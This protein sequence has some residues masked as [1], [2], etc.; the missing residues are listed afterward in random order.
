MSRR[1]T[2]PKDVK[3][4]PNTIKN[5]FHGRPLLWTHLYVCDF[6][7]LFLFFCFLFFCFSDRWSQD[8]AAGTPFYTCS[9]WRLLERP[10]ETALAQVGTETSWKPLLP[11]WPESLRTVSNMATYPEDLSGGHG[12]HTSLALSLHFHRDHR[13]L[14]SVEI[15]QGSPRAMMAMWS[16]QRRD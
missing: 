3:P 2:S 16:Q 9:Q 14:T 1:G 13:S 6:C 4:E 8:P 10:K 5:E 12:I 7:V 15:E 11:L